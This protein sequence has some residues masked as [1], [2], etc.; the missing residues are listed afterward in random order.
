MKEC[1]AKAL[2]TTMANHRKRRKFLHTA[3]KELALIGSDQPGL[4]GPKP[5]FGF[6]G[7][8]CS[9]GGTKTLLGF[10][11]LGYSRDKINWRLR[12]NENPPQRQCKV[13]SQEDQV[14]RKYGQAI[15]HHYV[16]YLAG[17]DGVALAQMT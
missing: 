5:L 10:M 17:Y 16:Q 14:D 2:A 12:H 9:R 15:Q 7:L 6:R 1:Y 11:G 3:L 4:L 8:G 13:K